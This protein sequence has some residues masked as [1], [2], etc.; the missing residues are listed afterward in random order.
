MPNHLQSRTN[1][2]HKGRGRHRRFS[3]TTVALGLVVAAVF[4]AILLLS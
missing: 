3:P 4:A 1:D 2:M